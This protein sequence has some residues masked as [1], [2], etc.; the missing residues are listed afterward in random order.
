MKEGPEE[1]SDEW[2]DGHRRVQSKRQDCFWSSGST[3]SSS[4]GSSWGAAERS[5]QDA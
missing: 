2:S 5:I 4:R 3:R 1:M